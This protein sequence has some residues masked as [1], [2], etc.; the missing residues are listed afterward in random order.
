M[1][2]SVLGAEVLASGVR[3]ATLQY[4]MSILMAQPWADCRFLLADTLLPW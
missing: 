3:G 2:W 4:K 1:S